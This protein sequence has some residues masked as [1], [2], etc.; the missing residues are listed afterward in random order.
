V[1]R[2]AH[3]ESEPAPRKFLRSRATVVAWVVV[4]PFSNFAK[5]IT[6][7]QNFHDH[8]SS[9]I[10]ALSTFLRKNATPPARANDRGLWLPGPA[11]ISS[12]DGLTSTTMTLL[13]G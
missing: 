4:S 10:Q 3:R 7:R 11:Q 12:L 5:L 8:G 9:A 1:L 13:G 2:V 6:G